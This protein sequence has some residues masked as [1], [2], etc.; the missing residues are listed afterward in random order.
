[1]TEANE[2]SSGAPVIV[3]VGLTQESKFVLRKVVG[4][5]GGPERIVAVHVGERPAI[6]SYVGAEAVTVIEEAQRSLREAAAG[7][8]AALCEPLGITQQVMTDGIPAQRLHALAK[9]HNA[10][11]IAVGSHGYH[12]WRAMLGETANSVLHGAPCDVF[13]IM[14]R[15]HTEHPKE[16]FDRV[17]VA[18]DMS[19]EASQVIEAAV[20]VARRYSATLSLLSVI[21]PF[22]F[23]YPGLDAPS[24]DPSLNF[25]RQAE[26]Q[27]NTQ[28]AELAARYE[29]AEYEVRH[30]TVAEEIHRKVAETDIDLV[31]TG[32]H[33]R[34][35]LGLLLGATPND[36]LHGLTCDL[37]AV[38]L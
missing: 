21:K 4:L 2:P 9:E 38:R 11:A 7:E 1:M 18:V 26:A 23:V 6:A 32:S 31:V 37:L 36:V 12:G 28:I 15:D 13:A 8:L 29:I 14:A 25:E 34:R 5:L 19:D 24:A 30:G 22:G 10:R 20:A 27:Y 3:G 33:A 35:G 17:L 16:T